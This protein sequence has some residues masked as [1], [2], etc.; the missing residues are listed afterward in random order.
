MSECGL[1]GDV[2]AAGCELENNVAHRAV[3]ISQALDLSSDFISLT[4]H[5]AIQEENG[6]GKK[7][8]VT[9]HTC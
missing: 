9:I 2:Q 6:E 3:Q 7:Q 4:Y 8:K 5:G 1:V